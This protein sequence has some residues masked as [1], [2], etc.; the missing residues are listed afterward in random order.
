MSSWYGWIQYI[1]PFK[2][3]FTSLIQNEVTNRS[4]SID[5]LN[6]DF[7]MWPSILMLL[8]LG[9]AMRVISCF[10]LWLKKSKLE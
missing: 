10:I 5:T 2:Y 3:G 7:E 6:L 4:S 8:A 9:L 1:S